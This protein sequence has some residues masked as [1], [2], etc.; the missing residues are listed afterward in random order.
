MLELFCICGKCGKINSV[1]SFEDDRYRLSLKIGKQFSLTCKFCGKADNRQVNQVFARVSPIYAILVY[2]LFLIF[3]CFSFY[4][5]L[6]E[7][8]RDNI[9]VFSKSIQIAVVGALIP[10]L[11]LTALSSSLKK[12]V[13]LFNMYRVK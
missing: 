1:F 12:R 10:I 13:R 7:Y 5:L 3:A 4:L 6:M 2:G 8:W 11:I 9:L